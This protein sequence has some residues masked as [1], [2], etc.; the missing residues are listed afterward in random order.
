MEHPIKKIKNNQTVIDISGVKENF[1]EEGDFFIGGE[2]DESFTHNIIAPLIREIKKRKEMVLPA[3]IDFFIS[4]YGGYVSQAFDLIT[5]FEHA[6]KCGLEIHTYV[7]SVAFSAASLIAVSGH[8]RY[9]SSRAYHGLH[10]MRGWDYAHNP[11]MA[12]RNAENHK[13]MQSELIKIY[14]QKTKLKD[15]EDK[16]LADNYMINGGANLLKFGFIDELLTSSP[17]K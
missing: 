14:K 10:F 2:I 1:E 13:W 8:K 12:E 6:K 15:I 7:T 4:S 11:N 5:W 3:P 16:L 9:G 17:D